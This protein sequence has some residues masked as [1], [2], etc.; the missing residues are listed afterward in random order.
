MTVATAAKRRKDFQ[1]GIKLIE[2]IEKGLKVDSAN[3]RARLP[4]DLAA[5]PARLTVALQLLWPWPT[6]GTTF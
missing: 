5:V 4:V 1:A 3:L 6:A 2:T